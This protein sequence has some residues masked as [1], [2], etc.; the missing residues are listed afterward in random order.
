MTNNS[1]A[2]APL[3]D[4]DPNAAEQLWCATLTVGTGTNSDGDT[5]LGYHANSS[6]GT[7]SPNTFTRGTA[8][9]TVERLQYTDTMEASPGI[10]GRTAIGHHPAEGLLGTVD[11][12]LHVDSLT[13]SIKN[14]GTTT[15]FSFTDHGVTWTD[16]QDVR[17]R[18]TRVPSKPDAPT[19][20]TAIADG[21]TQINLSW[22][23]PARDGGKPITGYLVEWSPDGTTNWNRLVASHSGTTYSDTGLTSGT[24]RHYRVSAI[25]QLGTS[26]ASHTASATTS[27]VDTAG[28]SFSRAD[29]P[30]TGTSLTVQFNEAIN[31]QNNALPD[32]NAFQVRVN[33]TNEPNNQPDHHGRRHQPGYPQPDQPDLPRPDRDGRLHRPDGPE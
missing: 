13:F 7:L 18:L 12:A 28:P 32:K 29:V 9:L 30:A 26:T 23:P 19:G 8:S 16:G 24:T 15:S 5:L 33:G 20:L 1:T 4:C 22:T 11:L 27:T 17:V 2:A 21:S 3:E 14:P 6:Q 10:R 25:N 31:L